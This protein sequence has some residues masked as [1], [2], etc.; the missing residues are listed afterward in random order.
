MSADAAGAD[1]GAGALELAR[2]LLLVDQ[3]QGALDALAGRQLD[4]DDPE[5]WAI[6]GWALTDLDRDEEAADTAR[7]ALARFPDDPDLY[8]S[9]R[10]PRRG[11][12]SSP[13]PR[14]RSS[15]RSRSSPTTPTCS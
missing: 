6:R 15:P 10:S 12:T 2:H 5:V 14:T 4:L 1:A 8:G 9:S 3:P 11:A 13:T 7:A